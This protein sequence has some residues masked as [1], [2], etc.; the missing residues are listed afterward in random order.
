MGKYLHNHVV[1]AGY[2]R[3]FTDA[4][5]RV[6][7]VDLSAP[8]GQRSELRRPERV[9]Y[10]TR[11]FS[12]REIASAMERQL[13][14][15]EGAGLE[16]LRDIDALWPLESDKRFDHRFKLALLV[17]VHM[18]RNPSFHQ[19]MARATAMALPRRLSEYKLDA[20]Q[21]EEL[22]QHLTSEHFVVERMISMIRQNAS[23]VASAHWT[24]LE[25]SDR[26]LATS[27]QPVT[28]VPV[29]P[30]GMSAPVDPQPTTGLLNCEEIRFPIDSR[31][32]LLF[33]WANELDTQRPL[34]AD[35]DLAAELNRATIA[36]ADQEWFHH[37]ARIPTRIAGGRLIPD[38]GCHP[39]AR[40]LLPDYDS[41]A[42]LESPRR[43]EARRCIERMT[44]E[45]EQSDENGKISI[46]VGR[47]RA[48]KF[49]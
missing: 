18:V 27:D 8:V 45:G 34:T 28:V 38:E 20:G 44:D 2:V 37:P 10:R 11:F 1:T 35:V 40:R 29:L 42:A 13:S 48:G 25:F 23:L 47:V 17:A 21:Q 14:V 9:G 15:I 30:D 3:R 32:A 46:Y 39:L 5:G 26:L 19:R 36:Q 33:S 41:V 16:V 22:L 12:N 4:S 6:T 49:R 7:R 24:L 43:H 31:R